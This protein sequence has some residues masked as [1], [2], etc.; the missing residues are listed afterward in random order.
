MLVLEDLH[1]SDSAT[2]DLLAML[3]RRRDPARLLVLATY[4]PAGRRRERA[5]APKP[6]KQELQLHGRCEELALDFLGEAAVARYLA[7]RFAE[8]AFVAAA[9]AAPAPQHERQPALPRE[10]RRR[11]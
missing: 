2:V 1:W 11:T 5:S 10:R 8:A 9:R 3:A 4:R 7:G 6:V